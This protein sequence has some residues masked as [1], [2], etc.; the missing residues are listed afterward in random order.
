MK[1]ISLQETAASL[2]LPVHTL[3]RWIR[4]GRIPVVLMDNFCVFRQETLARWARQ[5]NISFRIREK[6]GVCEGLFC[7]EGL[8]AALQRGSVMHHLQCEGKED[9]LRQMVRG[10]PLLPQAMEGIL[11]ER[12]LEREA[13][14]STGVGRGIALPHP[15]VPLD[16]FPEKSCIITAFPQDP[17]DYGAI[18]GHRVFVFFLLLA[19]DVKT[20]L[21][22]L[23]RLSHC[24]R[25]E[26]VYGLLME[27]PEKNTLLEML[28]AKEKV[29]AGKQVN[30]P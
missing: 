1:R 15:R 20:H 30:R 16:N 26:E 8:G 22:L 2:D 19:R 18:D 13:M 4:Q 11:L 21:H 17:M 6:D 12:L 27:K 3:E 25:D 10:V 7:S 14:V 29:F 23:S 28:V 24:L 9:L 5:H